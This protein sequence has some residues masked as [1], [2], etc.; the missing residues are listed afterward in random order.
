MKQRVTIVGVSTTGKKQPR[1]APCDC[2]SGKKA[3]RCCVYVKQ[4]DV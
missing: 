4:E 1:N 3:K 2:G